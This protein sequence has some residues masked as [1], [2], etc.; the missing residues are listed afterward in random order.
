[1]E[2]EDGDILSS[3]KIYIDGVYIHHYAPETITFCSG[4]KCDTYVDC[5]FGQHTFRLE[6][7]GYN[8]WEKTEMINAAG[9]YEVN[10]V[11]TKTS[12]TPAPT[13]TPTLTPS[14]TPVPTAKPLT[15]TPTPKVTPTPTPNPEV[16]GEEATGSGLYLLDEGTPSATPTSFAKDAS[17]KK[18]FLPLT[19]IGLGVVLV[20]ASLATFFFSSRQKA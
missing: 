1:L 9:S 13:S 20:F 18:N 19:A 8:N 3:V 6:K 4:C 14:P 2:N 12:A 10:P 11:M 5:G 7:T 15:P 16:L 17:S